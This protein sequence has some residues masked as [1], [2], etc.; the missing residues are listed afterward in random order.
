MHSREKHDESA[1]SHSPGSELAGICR[2]IK[3]LQRKT[4]TSSSSV[5]NC[6]I[7]SHSCRG[8]RET[9]TLE[10][11]NGGTNTFLITICLL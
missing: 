5:N 8:D 4:H 3:H 7:E 11:M 1:L 9:H 10:R 6:V 2:W